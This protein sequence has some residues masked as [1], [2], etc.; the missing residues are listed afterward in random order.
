MPL[1]EKLQS[2]RVVTEHFQEIHCNVPVIIE[3]SVTLQR[4]N[5][6]RLFPGELRQAI[7][8]ILCVCA[9]KL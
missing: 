6:S 7:I 2:A 8:E 1:K 4:N 5:L 3:K 9:T